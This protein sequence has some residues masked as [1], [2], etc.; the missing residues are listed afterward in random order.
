MI[1]IVVVM[2]VILLLLL[3]SYMHRHSKCGDRRDL[4]PGASFMISDLPIKVSFLESCPRRTLKLE[5]GSLR[6]TLSPLRVLAVFARGA[7]AGERQSTS[8]PKSKYL[9]LELGIRSAQRPLS[10]PPLCTPPHSERKKKKG[11]RK[12]EKGKEKIA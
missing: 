10:A 11:K 12:K 6:R 3:L 4:C 1:V 7:Q 9:E 2:I 8:C 5:A